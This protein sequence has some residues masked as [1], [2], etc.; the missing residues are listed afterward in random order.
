M[1]TYT[2]R[3]V[4]VGV[5]GSRSSLNAL[6]LAA[7]EAVLRQSPLR[8]VHVAR[9]DLRTCEAVVTDAAARVVR[10][11]PHLPVDV[12]VQRGAHP[13]P[14]LIEESG[15]S[16]LTVVGSQGLSGRSE[17]AKGR[18]AAPVLLHIRPPVR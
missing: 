16:A 11:Y 17:E 12:H 5:D 4:L 6:G 10:R 13:G 3:P 1:T 14:T 8:I 18:L 7:A 2:P 15:H 9:A